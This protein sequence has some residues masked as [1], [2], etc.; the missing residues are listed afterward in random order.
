MQ[1]EVLRPLFPTYGF[2]LFDGDVSSLNIIKYSRGINT[3]LHKSDGYPQ[4]V[5][6]E[7]INYFQ[8]LQQDDG[9]FIFDTKCIK[10]GDNIKILSGVFAGIKAIFKE[11][12]DLNRSNLLINLLGRI[13][14]INTKDQMIEKL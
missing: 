8:N 4:I 14:I 6:K 13:N 9:T 3:Y 11:K 10:Y 12:T 1:K 2:L 5:P 7:V